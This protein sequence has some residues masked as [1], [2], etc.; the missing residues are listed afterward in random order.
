MNESLIQSNSPSC[1]R[2]S[3]EFIHN[4]SS[5]PKTRRC[6][7]DIQQLSILEIA[8]SMEKYP[9]HNLCKILSARTG[10]RLKSVA[11]WFQNKRSTWKKKVTSFENHDRPSNKPGTKIRDLL[12]TN[13][14]NYGWIIL[15]SISLSTYIAEFM[16]LKVFFYFNNN[17]KNLIFDFLKKNEFNNNFLLHFLYSGVIILLVFYIKLWRCFP[18]EK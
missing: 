18:V 1:D 7:I 5:K 17:L 11:I 6:K 12:L 3:P 9:N 8:F 14:S 16:I 4:Q 2:G 10:L 15:Q 13:S